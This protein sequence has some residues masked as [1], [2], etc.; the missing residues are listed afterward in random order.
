MTR[1]VIMCLPAFMMLGVAC[2]GRPIFTSCF[3]GISAA[4]LL[5]L[6]AFYSQWY[7]VG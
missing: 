4:L 3:I 1:F 2:K 6:T 5:M 7:W